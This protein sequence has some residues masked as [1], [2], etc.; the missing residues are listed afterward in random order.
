MIDAKIETYPDDYDYGDT[1]YSDI[2][3]NKQYFIAGDQNVAQWH[4]YLEGK[5]ESKDF[6]K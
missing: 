2:L 4:E 1:E 3:Q 5:N 6:S